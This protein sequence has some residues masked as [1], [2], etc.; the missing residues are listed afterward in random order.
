MSKTRKS[1]G[2]YSARYIRTK[3]LHCSANSNNTI[4]LHCSKNSNKSCLNETLITYLLTMRLNVP[5]GLFHRH[6]IYKQINIIPISARHSLRGRENEFETKTYHIN[7]RIHKEWTRYDESFWMNDT[8][9]T[10]DWYEIFQTIISNKLW[11][12][13]FTNCELEFT[14][15]NTH[16]ILDYKNIEYYRMNYWTESKIILSRIW[17]QI[18][19]VPYSQPFEST[20]M[21]IAY[22][23]R[24]Y[25]PTIQMLIL[26]RRCDL[27]NIEYSTKNLIIRKPIKHTNLQMTN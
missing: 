26:W 25:T 6:Y 16:E 27:S 15:T 19:H 2:N 12:H 8:W 3:I 9:L 20:S 24:N 1:C 7:W 14:V 22:C 4:G 5:L 11:R 17:S 23:L 10:L 21:T 18:I 13:E